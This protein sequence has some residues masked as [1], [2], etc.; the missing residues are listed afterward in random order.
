VRRAY[1]FRLYPNA[2]QRRELAVMLQTHRRRYNAC[3]QQRR[4]AWRG[5]QRSI[6]YT[7]QSAWFKAERTTNPSY[8]RTNVSSA[9]ATMRQLD[10]AFTAFFRRVKAGE[11]PGY[12]RFRRADGSHRSASPPGVT[13]SA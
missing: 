4:D 3:L 5:Q 6:R 13:G 11:Q 12:P 8:A 2:N 1:K 9:Q 7:E 10:R